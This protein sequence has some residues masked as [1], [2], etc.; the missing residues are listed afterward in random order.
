ME[1]GLQK[2]DRPLARGEL[3][4]TNGEYKNICTM[5]TASTGHWIFLSG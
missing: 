1:Q 2:Y 4:E 5:R 3:R